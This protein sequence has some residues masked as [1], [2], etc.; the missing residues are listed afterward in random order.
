MSVGALLLDSPV[1]VHVKL[2]EVCD[3]TILEFIELSLDFNRM[4]GGEIVLLL[5]VK[6]EKDFLQTQNCV[7]IPNRN[8]LSN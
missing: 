7:Q 6:L 3:L 5:S 4:I 8:I 2:F 1:R